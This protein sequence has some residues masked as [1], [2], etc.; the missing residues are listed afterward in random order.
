MSKARVRRPAAKRCHLPG[1]HV[2]LPFSVSFWSHGPCRRVSAGRWPEVVAPPAPGPAEFPAGS[3]GPHE[4][5][6]Y[7]AKVC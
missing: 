5:S 7:R 6:T 1:L 4:L 3:F 2:A